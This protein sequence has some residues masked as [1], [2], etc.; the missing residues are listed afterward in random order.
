MPPQSGLFF[1]PPESG[2][3]LQTLQASHSAW[4]SASKGG[5]DTPGVHP[6]TW[7][8]GKPSGGA[9][10]VARALSTQVFPRKPADAVDCDVFPCTGTVFTRVMS[11]R[12]G[13]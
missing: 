11:R 10:A 12:A 1:W 6:H 9:G 5:L 13:L 2:L 4:E 8:W 7:P 3:S